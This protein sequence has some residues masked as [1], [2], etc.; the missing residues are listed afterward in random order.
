[1]ERAAS[2]KTQRL[3]VGSFVGVRIASVV[4]TIG[5]QLGVSQYNVSVAF[6]GSDKGVQADSILNKILFGPVCSQLTVPKR[7]SG[8][9]TEDCPYAGNTIEEIS[10]NTAAKPNQ[11]PGCLPHLLRFRQQPAP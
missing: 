2:P 8:T 10:T 9:A 11:A 7:N 5:P 3:E 6:A 4:P 1:M